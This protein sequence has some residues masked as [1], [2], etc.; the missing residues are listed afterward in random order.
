MISQMTGFDD[1]PEPPVWGGSLKALRQEEPPPDQQG[2]CQVLVMAKA[3][4][5]M[6]GLPVEVA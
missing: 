3:K 1:D 4:A 5:V 6:Y 2:Y